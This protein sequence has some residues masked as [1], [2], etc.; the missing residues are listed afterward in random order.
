VLHRFLLHGVAP[1]N[2]WHALH[3]HAGTSCCFGA[4]TSFW[5]R[6]FGTVPAKARVRQ[7]TDSGAARRYKAIHT[8]IHEIPERATA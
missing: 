7:R 2:R 6:A 3:H 4:T 1:F 8:E 5:D